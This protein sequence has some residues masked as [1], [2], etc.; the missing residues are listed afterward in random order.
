MSLPADGTAQCAC[1]HALPSDPAHAAANTPALSTARVTSSIPRMADSTEQANW[2]YPSTQMFYDAMRRKGHAPDAAD[3]QLVVDIHNI[4]NEK[5]WVEVLKWE[6]MH[7]AE[8]TTASLARF[9]GRPDTLSPKAWLRHHLLGCTRPFDR[10]DWYVDRCGR[11]VRYIIDFYAAQSKEAPVS[12]HLDVRPALDSFSA[13]L[14]R[15]A[16]ASTTSTK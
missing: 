4:V 16:M 6:R 8:C 1:P 13:L 5:C 10:H 14:D 3:M 2:I 12:F 7:Q 11:Q 15:I 9:T